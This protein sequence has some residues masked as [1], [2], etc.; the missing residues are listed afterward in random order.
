MVILFK[1]L[2]LLYFNIILIGLT[3]GGC[4][5]EFNRPYIILFEVFL[6]LKVL[7]TTEQENAGAR[8]GV[9]TNSCKM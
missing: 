4:S 6:I 2:Y 3:G 5:N 1:I 8:M 9:L 7:K